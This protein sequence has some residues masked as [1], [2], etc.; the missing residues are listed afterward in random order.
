LNNTSKQ[1]LTK[2][3]LSYEERAGGISIFLSGN[4]RLVHIL[5]IREQLNTLPVSSSTR[6]QLNGE[7]LQQIDTSGAM[8]LFQFFIARG[9]NLNN[10]EIVKFGDD[11]L[12]ILNLVKNRVNV[13]EKIGNPDSL[14]YLESVGAASIGAYKKFVDFLSFLGEVLLEAISAIIRPKQF[15]W[16][17]T[18]VQLENVCLNAIPVVCLVTFLIGV[19]VAYLF[20]DQI[21]KYGANIFIVDGVSISM[22]RE[23]SPIIVAIIIA[24]RSGSAFTAQIGTMKLNDE[25]DAMNALGLSPLHILVLPRLLALIIALPL[26]VFI[27]DIIGIVGG[28]VVADVQLGVAVPTFIDRLHTVIPVKHAIVGFIKAPV[29]AAFIA[30]IGCRMGL[31]VE[32][33]ARSVGINTTSTVVQSIVSV[34]LLNAGFAVIF[35]ELGV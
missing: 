23:L 34:I 9:V 4:W 6:V 26:L 22:F 10:L 28:M 12:D 19:V 21:Q 2:S 5:Q 24:G 27:G 7:A 32:H 29:F 30:L 13:S 20:A 3:F 25:I 18:F 31:V 1:N 14:N 35:V 17:E 16:R 15:R 8:L 11:D 33:N